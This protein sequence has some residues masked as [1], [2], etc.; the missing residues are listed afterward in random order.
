MPS[1]LQKMEPV[2]DKG[3][4]RH[5]VRMQAGSEGLQ[6]LY[7]Y[8]HDALMEKTQE[9]IMQMLK[10]DEPLLREVMMRSPVG[11]RDDRSVM[12]LLHRIEQE[13]EPVRLIGK[14]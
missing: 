3:T 12:H 6:S 9:R 14:D 5:V 1:V 4:L 10:E 2:L 7:I 8:H 13:Y 11:Y